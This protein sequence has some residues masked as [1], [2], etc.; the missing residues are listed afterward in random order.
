MT[1][2]NRRMARRVTIWF[3]AEGGMP[4]PSLL[5]PLVALRRLSQCRFAIS[6]RQL[7]D[8]IRMV[9]R[10]CAVN[11]GQQGRGAHTRRPAS[12]VCATI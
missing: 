6:M 3:K 9:R 10:L 7:R 11:S 5:R 12:Y 4:P 8:V 1:G 2:S